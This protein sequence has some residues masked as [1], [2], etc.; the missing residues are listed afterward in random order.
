MNPPIGIEALPKGQWVVAGDTHLGA[1]AKQHGNIVTD[2][3]LFRW[4]KPYLEN[5]KVVWDIGANIGDHTR[6]YLNWGMKVV[7]VE[8]NPITFRCLAHNCPEAECFNVAASEQTAELKFTHLDNVGASRVTPSGEITVSAY[9]LDGFFVYRADILPGF[10]KID[11][12]GYEV[13]ALRGMAKTI[14]LCKPILFVEMNQGALSSNG[15]TP[16]DI[17]SLTEEMGYHVAAI[18]PPKATWDDPQFD[19]LFLPTT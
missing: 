1:W 11:I 2:P 12:E 19:V 18:Y 4:L 9:P 7:A 10:I 14:R 5:V 8:P 6:Q 3:C 16:D 15:H 17:V 13:F